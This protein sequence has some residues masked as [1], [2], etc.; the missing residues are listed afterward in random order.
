MIHNFGKTALI[1]EVTLGFNPGSKSH[2]ERFPSKFKEKK[3]ERKMKGV[4]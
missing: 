1:A 3:R 2:G 4:K